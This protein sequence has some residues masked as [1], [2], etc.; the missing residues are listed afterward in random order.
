MNRAIKFSIVVPLHNEETNITPL[1]VRLMGYPLDSG[2][3][4]L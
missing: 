2:D 1:Y 3:H 4:N